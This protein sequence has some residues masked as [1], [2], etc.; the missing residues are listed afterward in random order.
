MRD[1][2]DRLASKR[3]LGLVRIQVGPSGF[4]GLEEWSCP[5]SESQ[6][7]LTK[8]HRVVASLPQA[9]G[10]AKRLQLLFDGP[11]PSTGAS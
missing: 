10:V 11:L 6:R 9:P 8:H 5:C 7:Q 3:G 4:H 1:G 2:E